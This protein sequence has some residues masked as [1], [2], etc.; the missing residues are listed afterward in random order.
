MSSA[1]DSPSQTIDTTLLMQQ[2]A[3]LIALQDRSLNT[4]NLQYRSEFVQSFRY[5]GR[6][7]RRLVSLHDSVNDMLAEA[8]R[9]AHVANA[10]IVN[11]TDAENRL[12]KSYKE[13]MRWIPSIR[14]IPQTEL[15]DALL[16]LERG[17]DTGRTDDT[18]RLK[19]FV[20]NWL[21]QQ[22][23]KP[24]PPLSAEDKSGRGFYNDATGSFLCPVD[25]DW[26]VPIHR[27][28]IRDFHPDFLVTA[29]SWPAFLY[30]G[31]QSDPAN[32]DSGLFKN[33]ILVKACSAHKC[34]YRH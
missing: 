12:Y 13:L 1:D 20:V 30:A 22:T 19:V 29:Q 14:D 3:R 6:L 16:Q 4:R 26:N 2:V 34:R 28:N 15:G 21:M 24:E 5:K 31:G 32:L 33:E 8:D 23:P 17:A 18:H 10:N 11:H 25:Y 9:R 27:Q 7:I